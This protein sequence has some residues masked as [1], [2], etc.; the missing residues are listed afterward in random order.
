M[1]FTKK[2]KNNE[3]DAVGTLHVQFIPST[4]KARGRTDNQKRR[5]LNVTQ[6]IHKISSEDSVEDSLE[7]TEEF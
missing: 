6:E 2:I 3:G 5:K 1:I 4:V 7:D